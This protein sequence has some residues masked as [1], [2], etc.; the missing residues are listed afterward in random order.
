MKT[1]AIWRALFF[2]SLATGLVSAAPAPPRIFY[3]DLISGPNTG[4]PNNGGAIVTLYGKRFGASQGSSVVT[5][6]GGHV[7]AYPCWS[8]SKVCV[9][10]GPNA[11]SGDIVLTTAAGA[12]N[13][14]HF[15]VRKGRI[16]FVSTTGSDGNAGSFSSPW[17]TLLKARDSMKPGDI[18]YAMNGVAQTTDDGQGWRTCY[19]LHEGGRP[20]LPMALVAYPGAKVT[21]GDPNSNLVGIRSDGQGPGFWVFAGLT[22]R[23]QT[24]A[25]I[26]AAG[27]HWRFVGND[28]S[29]PNGDGPSA[30]VFATQSLHMKFLGN[31]IHDTGRPSASA[32]YHGLYFATDMNF[33]EVGWNTVANVRGCRGMQ[34]NSSPVNGGGPS[35]TTGHNLFALSIHDNVIHDTQCDGIILATVDPSHGRVELFNNIIYNAG[36]G[37][38]NPENTGNWACLYVA[39][40]TGNG[41]P[42]GGVVHVY[43]NTFFNCGT[44]ASPPYT[45]STTAV[46]N[47]GHNPNLTV[48]LRD[49]LVYEPMNIPYL[50]PRAGA[51]GIRGHNNLFYGSGSAPALANSLNSD[52]LWVNP[53]QGDFHL[54]NGSPARAAGVPSEADTDIDGMPR[55]PDGGIDLGA[56]QYV[57]GYVPSGQPSARLRKR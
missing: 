10:V 29:C 11:Q 53:F 13:G 46:M 34:F 5:I 45:D 23:G 40:Y 21:I 24:E 22:V 1:F 54:Q 37:P 17:Q 27:E 25:V 35:D 43:H 33:A 14:Q 44:F 4:G 9:Q 8:D 42:G 26:A 50:V 6:G 31:T 38:A 39:G 49:N 28:F 7:L 56:Y 3:T 16:Y 41:A 2:Y 19:K 12:S 15:Q 36:K 47:G 20:G 51:P 52:P 48:A 18:T 32:L 55:T 57:D 30:C